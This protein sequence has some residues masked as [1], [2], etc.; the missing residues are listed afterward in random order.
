MRVERLTEDHWTELRDIRLR[1]LREGPAWQAAS[2]ERETGFT[3][4]H[5]RM[6]LRSTPWFV[7]RQPDDVVVGLVSVTSEPGAPPEERHL[8]GGWVAPEHRGAG[9]AT[10]LIGAAEEQARQDG[11]TLVS[12]WLAD[13]D[14][15]AQ[16]LYE[17]L[18]YA[19]SGV[20]MPI[21]R[22]RSRM[23]ERWVKVVTGK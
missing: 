20:R 9:A 4:S 14:D 16:R 3:E 18:G 21:P 6:R 12:T 22:D 2:L 17:R 13:G 7:A 1:A 11:A 15:A 23:E 19:P 5:W 10:A 8:I